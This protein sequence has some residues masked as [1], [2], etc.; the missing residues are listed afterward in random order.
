MANE[1]E[2]K[3]NYCVGRYWEGNRGSIGCYTYLGEVKY[4]TMEE[5]EGFLAYVKRQGPEKDYKI[6]KV[7]ELGERNEAIA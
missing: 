5:A 3:F 2:E 7:V 4:G 6:F 1:T